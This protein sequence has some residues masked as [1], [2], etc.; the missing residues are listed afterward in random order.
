V[1]LPLFIRR[2]VSFYPALGLSCACTVL[3]YIAMSLAL[4]RFGVK[5]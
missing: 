3:G 4:Q 5:V 1:V 2:G